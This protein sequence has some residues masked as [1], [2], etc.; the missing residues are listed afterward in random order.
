M[1]NKPKVNKDERSQ[2]VFYIISIASKLSN[3]HP[4]TLRYYDKLGLVSP[5]RASGR[6]RRYSPGDIELLLMIQNLVNEGINLAG[7]KQILE[8]KR[9]IKEIEE[10]LSWH[11]KQ[12]RKRTNLN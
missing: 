6:G 5:H 12:L 2:E 4:Q 8:L 11:K 10:A 9:R 7:V 3:M 1:S